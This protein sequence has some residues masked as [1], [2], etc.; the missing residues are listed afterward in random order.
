MDTIY[1]VIR[2]S[3]E[4]H[5][6]LRHRVLATDAI[7]AISRTSLLPIA[8]GSGVAHY[9]PPI[10]VGEAQGMAVISVMPLVAMGAEWMD[11]EAED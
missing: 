2:S 8:E 4:T 6:V 10:T 3:T 11:P 7:D 1:E 5:R 9:K